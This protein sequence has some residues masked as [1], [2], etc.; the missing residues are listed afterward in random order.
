MIRFVL[1][2]PLC[3]FRLNAA[4]GRILLLSLAM[5]LA[6]AGAR[7]GEQE[8]QLQQN[9]LKVAYLY[10][11]LQLV[12]WP[13]EDAVSADNSFVI[14][15]VG[16]DPFAENLETLAKKKVRGRGIVIKRFADSGRLE[17]CHLLFVNLPGAGSLPEVLRKLEGSSTLTVSDM[18]EFVGQGGMI[19]FV[20]AAAEN[21]AGVKVRFEV[22]LEMARKKGLQVSSKLLELATYV[23][24]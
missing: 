12:K 18:R 7:A 1:R 2:F 5:L 4:F 15:V 22:N 9:Q 10:H 23:K 24:Q 13:G 16:K 14:G 17:P 8:S 21:E 3:R 19:G 20:L 11:F 6:G